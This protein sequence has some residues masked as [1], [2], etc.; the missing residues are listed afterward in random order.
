MLA[1][2]LLW[3]LQAAV[4]LA[5]CVACAGIVITYVAF[6]KE[7]V[8][9]HRATADSAALDAQVVAAARAKLDMPV[10]AKVAPMVLLRRRWE[11]P[12]VVSKELGASAG[13]VRSARSSPQQL[14]RLRQ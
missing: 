14:Q 9:E 8:H 4:L 1:A 10:E 13:V 2:A 12:T 6:G 3:L 11:T 7:P 5:V